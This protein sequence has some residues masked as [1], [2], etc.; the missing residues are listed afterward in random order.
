MDED[1]PG[2]LEHLQYTWTH[3]KTINEHLPRDGP[4]LLE[5]LARINGRWRQKFEVVKPSLQ[6]V[7]SC[8]CQGNCTRC[9]CMKT[10]QQR[11]AGCMAW[12]SSSS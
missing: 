7:L 2:D 9:V 10:T 1:A 6:P 8:A 11:L 4:R 3:L 5:W 12:C